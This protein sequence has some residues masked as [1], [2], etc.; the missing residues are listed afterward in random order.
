MRLRYY[1]HMNLGSP[2]GVTLSF[3]ASSAC[4]SDKG[5]NQCV[6]TEHQLLCLQKVVSKMHLTRGFLFVAP[7]FLYVKSLFT[8]F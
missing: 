7:P 1:N 5:A 8:W 6:A 4:V 2:V 3:F